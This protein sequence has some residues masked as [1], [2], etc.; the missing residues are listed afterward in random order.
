[1][2]FSIFLTMFLVTFAQS[3]DYGTDQEA[4]LQNKDHLQCNQRILQHYGFVGLDSAIVPPPEEQDGGQNYC[5]G[6][7]HTCCQRDDFLKSNML[8]DNNSLK[9]KGYL[10]KLFR[11]IQKI[12]LMQDSFIEVA[13]KI[14]I[15]NP[16]NMH[17]KNVDTTFFNSPVAFDEIYTYIKTA[18]QAMGYIQKGFYCTICDVKNHKYMSIEQDYSRLMIAMSQKSCHDIAYYFREYMMYKVYY[19]DPYMQ[20]MYRLLNCYYETDTYNY[21][22]Q[23][24]FRYPHVKT[25]VEGKDGPGKDAACEFVCLDFRFGASSKLFMGDLADYDKFLKDITE[26]AKEQEVEMALDEMQLF[27]PDYHYEDNSF[28]KSEKE[29]TDFD[30]FELN[31]S[32]ISKMQMLVYKD[33][34]DIFGTA[35]E[36]NY[37]LTDQNSTIEKTRIFNINATEEQNTS[38]LEKETSK[39]SSLSPLDIEEEMRE[40]EKELKH[41]EIQE[42]LHKLKQL[43]PEEIPTA[44]ELENLDEN[45]ERDNHL[46]RETDQNSQKEYNNEQVEDRYNDFGNVGSLKSSMILRSSLGLALFLCSYLFI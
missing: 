41:A 5:M 21:D 13:N 23:Y 32:D 6:M 15:M 17:C 25:C 3:F 45:I 43:N 22:P 34:I 39:Q 12:V 10:T 19:L 14:T 29:F 44:D 18:F 38:L 8:W 36:S 40:E 26:F 27:V 20:N 28:F 11:I 7:E 24:P 31:Y 4:A 46:K 1:M 2:K 33:G 42:H 16:D 30:K 9:I 37:F 35:E